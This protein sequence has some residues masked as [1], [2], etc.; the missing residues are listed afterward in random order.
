MPGVQVSS[1][2]VG[3]RKITHCLRKH[4]F[5][6][7][8]QAVSQTEHRHKTKID[9]SSQTFLFLLCPGLRT[10]VCSEHTHSLI[11]MDS[12]DGFEGIVVLRGNRLLL[13]VLVLL[14]V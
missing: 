13:H 8:L 12:V 5:V 14:N 4:C 7:V 2:L 1:P 10:L 3:Y 9:L 6:I 11:L